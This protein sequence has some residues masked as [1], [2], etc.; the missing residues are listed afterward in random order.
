MLGWNSWM[1]TNKEIELGYHFLKKSC[2]F[3][4][5]DN[6]EYDSPHDMYFLAQNKTK[7]SIFHRT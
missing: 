5:L 6:Q 7:I 2:L 1:T 4:E 3:S